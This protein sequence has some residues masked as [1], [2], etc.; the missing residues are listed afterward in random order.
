M[1]NVNTDLAGIRALLKPYQEQ[2]LRVLI[3]AKKNDVFV[4]TRH[5]MTESNKVL[6]A[7][8][9]DPRSRAS[10]IN[11]VKKLA[12]NGIVETETGTGKGGTRD[13]YKAFPGG[14]AAVHAQIAEV[15]VRKLYNAFPVLNLNNIVNEVQGLN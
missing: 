14:W 9:L 2:T 4:G 5:I 6:V 13:N 10:Y 3:E 7:D 1:F 8:D 15:V 12:K 11:Y